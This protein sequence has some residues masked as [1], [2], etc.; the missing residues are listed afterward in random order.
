MN[1][2]NAELGDKRRMARLIRTADLMCR[3]PGGTLP[4]KSPSPKDLR[5]AYRL[6][7]CDQVTHKSLLASHQAVT[8]QK[9]KEQEGLVLVLH[10]ATELDYM[11]HHSLTGL[12]QIGNGKHRG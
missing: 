9:V 6:F 11:T 3:R 12:G 1:F 8:H 10:D 2:G 5:G 7:Q 4:Q